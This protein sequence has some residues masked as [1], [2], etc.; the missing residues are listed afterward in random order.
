MGRRGAVA[1]DPARS[2]PSSI[3]SPPSPV[4]PGSSRMPPSPPRTA[5][6][7]MVPVSQ[8]EIAPPLAGPYPPG[9]ASAP[10]TAHGPQPIPDLFTVFCTTNFDILRITNAC[11]A[12]TGFHPQEFINLNLNRWVHPAD[13]HIL[14]AERVNLLSVSYVQN[15]S[16][17]QSTREVTQAI[18]SYSERELLTPAIGMAEPYPQ[19]NVRLLR[20]DHGYSYYNV[21][22][23]LGG[24]LGGS[25]WEPESLGNLYLVVSCL[26]IS[27]RDVPSDRPPSRRTAMALP[28]APASA[29]PPPPP[30]TLPSFSS[31]AAVAEAPTRAP[32]DPREVRG[33][34][35]D[36]APR[37]P[38]RRD[39]R[40]A[41]ESR[42][43]RDTR[44]LR[45]SRFS[46]DHGDTRDLREPHRDYRHSQQYYPRQAY[47]SGPVRRTPSPPA[48]YPS[49][50]YPPP[51]YPGHEQV[52]R[53]DDWRRRSIALPPSSGPSSV[54]PGSHHP[55]PPP[56]GPPGYPGSQGDYRRT[57][58][59]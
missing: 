19:V 24:G 10:P 56:P 8:G 39:T 23:H 12:L 57:W 6:G 15:Q 16:S 37:I 51:Y 41:R 29:M 43:F 34:P 5:V 49:H 30:H 53:E 1:Y 11:H 25:L 46:R 54:Q 33:D 48:P 18:R 9:P 47:P 58:E 17:A 20:A 50:Y 22:L 40:E 45:D 35:R 59:L 52:R 31:V 36:F 14:D 28:P 27:D 7:S 4:R 42:T 26:L 13:Q 3:N 44:D 38:E 2:Y 32:R 21:R 55:P